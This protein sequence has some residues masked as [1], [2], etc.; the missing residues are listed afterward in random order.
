MLNNMKQNTKEDN[1]DSVILEHSF[2]QLPPE[3]RT[4]LRDYLQNLVSIQKTLAGA[5]TVDDGKSSTK[6][7]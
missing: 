2:S 1:N 4:Q 3:G 6:N 5:V 7:K